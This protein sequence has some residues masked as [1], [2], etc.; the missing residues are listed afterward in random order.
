MADATKYRRIIAIGDIHGCVHALDAILEVIAPTKQDLI[1][2]LG[3][4]IDMG[5][6][7]REVIERLMALQETSNLVCIMCNHEQMLLGA[8]SSDKLRN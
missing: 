5:R 6:E 8:L 7:T 3:D 1:I 4:F 2:S